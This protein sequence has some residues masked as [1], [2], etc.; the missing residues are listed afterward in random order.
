VIGRRVRGGMS[1]A[2]GTLAV[3]GAFAC[4]SGGEPTGNVPPP[5]PPP[6]APALDVAQWV[7]SADGTIPLV[8]VAP[9]GGA[10]APSELPNRACAGC[11]TV[12]DANT[13]LLAMAIADAFQRRIAM[14]PFVVANLLSR[15]KFDANRALD[16]ATAGYAPLAPLHELFH[17]RIDSAKARATRVHPNALLIDLHGHGHAIARL[18]LG[19]LLTAANLRLSDQT[20]SP[21]LGS[22]SVARLNVASAAGDSGAALLRGPRAMGTRFTAAGFESVPSA[23][24]PAPAEA[25][26]YFNGGYNAQ[27]HGS[28]FGGP[29]DAVQIE[30]YYT[31][32]RDTA[33]A[34]TEFAEAFVTVM[35]QYLADH[36]GWSPP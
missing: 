30:C 8:I 16:E 7:S 24:Q 1:W 13:R 18:E 21:L 12:N 25:D 28:R 6:P 9:H 5:G 2:L 20:L 4:A 10:L 27:R 23:N 31:G 17:E 14:R 32:L 33:V 34:R 35:L 22:S 15:T 29:V 11:E 3:L 36:Y 26:P 19:Y